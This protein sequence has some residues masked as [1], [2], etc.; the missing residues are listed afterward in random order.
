MEVD[1]YIDSFPN[2]VKDILLKVRTLITEIAPESTEAMSYGMPGYKYL[3]KSLI[4]FAAFK[5]HLGIYATPSSHEAFSKQ[6]SNY[7]Q[8]KGSVQFQFNQE[9][10][11]DL[12]REMIHFKMGEIAQK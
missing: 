1:T 6:L 11:F 9:I 2:K 4:Y 7:K 12:I 8:G 5:K 3:G 10:P